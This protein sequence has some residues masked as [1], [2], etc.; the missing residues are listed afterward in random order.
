MTS[1]RQK[2]GGQSLPSIPSFSALGNL[3][4]KESVPAIPSFSG[5]S[6]L[7]ACLPTNVPRR[8]TESL[9]FSTPLIKPACPRF[10][11]DHSLFL[12]VG[13]HHHRVPL[14]DSSRHYQETDTF[15]T[16]TSC[17]TS[18]FG[19]SQSYNHLQ[20]TNFDQIITPV[21]RANEYN[22]RA[23]DNNSGMFPSIDMDFDESPALN[24]DGLSHPLSEL[25]S[26][27]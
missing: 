26:M 27:S 13:Q 6:S 7:D 25:A 11:D 24:L 18:T 12:E 21:P 23:E 14:N 10:A 9:D 17:E 20:D 2:T 5:L 19:T 3:P 16:F 8:R 22:F 4:V 1:K 15:A